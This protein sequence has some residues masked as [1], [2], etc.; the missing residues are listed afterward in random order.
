MRPSRR[1]RG[2]VPQVNEFGKSVRKVTG[3]GGRYRRLKAATYSRDRG[4]REPAERR[5]VLPPRCNL[6]ALAPPRVTPHPPKIKRPTDGQHIDGMHQ[7]ASMQATTGTNHAA[8]SS[9]GRKMPQLADVT[10]QGPAS[11][12]INGAEQLT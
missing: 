6:Y 5:V 10:L 1:A 4:K 11:G 2:V 3:E 9:C 12:G 8:L 7:L